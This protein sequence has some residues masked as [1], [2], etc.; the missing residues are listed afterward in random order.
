MG[1]EILGQQNGDKTGQ[2]KSSV[3]YSHC[4]TNELRKYIECWFGDTF[5]HL[6]KAAVVGWWMLV[7]AMKVLNYSTDY[8]GMQYDKSCISCMCILRC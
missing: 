7:S 2:Q 8:L 4:I 5:V 6:F 1:C 3:A